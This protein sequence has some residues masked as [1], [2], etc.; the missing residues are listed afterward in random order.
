M[1][2]D[3]HNHTTIGSP[4]S[5]LSPEELVETAKASGLD[6][7]C[8]TDHQFIQGADMTRKIGVKMGFPVFRGI[9][10]RTEMGDMLVYGYYEDIPEWLPLEDLFRLVHPV[11]AVVFAAHPFHTSGGWNLHD[12]L[13]LQEGRRLDREEKT[14][15]HLSPLNGIEVI[16]GQVSVE[17]NAKARE[18]A[19]RLGVPGIG[20][21]DAHQPGM[22][23]RAATE[24]ADPI[25]SDEALVRALKA[26]RYTAVQLR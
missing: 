6:A 8:V 9:E 18:L 15:P 13:I 4:C 25:D 10:A 11:G 7:I 1:L 16:N 14:S 20:G 21:S 19:D 5:A 22:I 26:G 2:I 24:F 23:G 3:L 17:N 12:A